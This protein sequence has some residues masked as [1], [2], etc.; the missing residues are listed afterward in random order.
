MA[1]KRIVLA[2]G[3][4]FLGQALAQ[5]LVKQ[6]C[7]VVILTRT[8]NHIV[9]NIRYVQW[10]GKT[11]GLWSD[12][13]DGADAVVN[14]TGKSVNCRYTP[15]NRREIVDSRVNSVN[16]LGRAILKCSVPPRVWVQAASLAI[17][18]DAGSQVCDESTLPGHGFSPETC[19]TWEKTFNSLHLPNTRKV[20][21]R[22]GFALDPHGGAL[23]T[24]VRLTRYFLG[25]AAGSGK[26]FISWLHIADLNRVFIAAIEHSD[27][28]GIFNRHYSE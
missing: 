21:L 13:L 5:D 2:G 18:G 19:V 4:G 14:L 3:S 28:D 26:Q 23:G 7:E 12:T 10:D 27:W 25:G 15:A 11:L 1:S 9:E 16:I 20:L 24:L 6:G 22:I 8:P 17:Y